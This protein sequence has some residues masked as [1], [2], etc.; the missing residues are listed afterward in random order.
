M[1]SCPVCLEDLEQESDIIV[2]KCNHS[3]HRECLIKWQK[4]NITCPLCRRF[5]FNEFKI[6]EVFHIRNKILTISPE[7]LIFKR[8]NKLL[9]TIPINMIKSVNIKCFRLYLYRMTYLQ[10]IKYNRKI[11]K[12]DSIYI[13]NNH[14]HI[15]DILKDMFEKYRN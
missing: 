8:G 1:D 9:N 11:K 3:F 12:L 14:Q 4:K 10:I 15:Y 13:F 5:I 7:N 6:R 2:T